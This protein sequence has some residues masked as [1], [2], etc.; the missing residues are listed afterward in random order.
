MKD[1]I[2]SSILNEKYIGL[3]SGG[4]DDDVDTRGGS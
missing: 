1:K 4:T 2:F 3:V